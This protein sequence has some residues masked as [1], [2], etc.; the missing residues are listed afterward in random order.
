MWN[1]SMCNETSPDDISELD[2]IC[3]DSPLDGVHCNCWYDGKPCCWCGD[4]GDQDY[5]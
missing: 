4:D 3:L 5:A 1:P 2:E